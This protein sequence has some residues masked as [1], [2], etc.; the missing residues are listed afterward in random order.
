[1]C[2]CVW[3]GGGGGGGGGGFQPV[4]KGNFVSC[5]MNFRL[6]IVIQCK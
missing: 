1:M 5:E 4:S 6:N 3:G 2:V